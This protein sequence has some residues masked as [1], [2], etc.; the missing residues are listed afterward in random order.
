MEKTNVY[1]T[2]QQK[3]A[4]AKAAAA[5]GRSEA[6]M[7]RAAIDLITAARPTRKPTLPL[8]ESGVE[9]LATR[10]DELL[11]GFGER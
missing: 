4:L 5:Q 11:E 9:D 10:H 3:R 2:E 8:F 6:D 1:L 7:I